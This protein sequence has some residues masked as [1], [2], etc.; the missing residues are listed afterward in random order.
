MDAT[1]PADRGR[2]RRPRTPL[3]IPE[4][5]ARRAA[6]AYVENENGCWISTYSTGSHGYAQIGWNEDGRI[7]ATTAHRAAWVYSAGQQIP[8]GITIDH[9]CKTP[10]CVNP[11]HLRLLSNHENARRTSGRDWPLGYCAHGHPNDRLTTRGSKLVCSECAADWQ[12]TYRAKKRA[13]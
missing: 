7:R 10:R 6:T 8:A 12:R 3:I 2:F 1:H 4:R 9:L 11:S 13:A 5:A